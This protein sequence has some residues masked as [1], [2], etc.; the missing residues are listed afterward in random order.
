MFIA[1]NT[2]DE[3]RKHKDGRA[4]PTHC[5]PQM[6]VYYWNLKLVKLSHLRVTSRRRSPTRDS[7]ATGGV[8]QATMIP[9]GSWL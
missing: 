4:I 6:S 1:V 8:T 7:S 9:I 2:A 5:S 3:E